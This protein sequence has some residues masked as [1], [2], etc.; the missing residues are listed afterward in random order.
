MCE[1]TDGFEIAEADLRFRGPGDL[2][3]TQQSGMAFDLHVANLARDGQLVQLARD[4]ANRI[5]DEDP[6]QN[7]PENARM[8]AYLRQLNPVDIDWSNIS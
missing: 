1:T 3:G 7:R 2:E 8:W 5:L 6:A 4:V